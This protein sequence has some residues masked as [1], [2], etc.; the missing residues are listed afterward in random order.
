VNPTVFP[1][2]RPQRHRYPRDFLINAER[3][4]RSG[5]RE[6][7]VVTPLP[8]TEHHDRFIADAADLPHGSPLGHRAP[9][10]ETRLRRQ[11]GRTAAMA[12]RA[13]ARIGVSRLV[14]GGRPASR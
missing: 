13:A 1:S 10:G 12:A 5:T 14:G 4:A 3:A 11:V 2:P 8:I 6:G 7:I 9:E